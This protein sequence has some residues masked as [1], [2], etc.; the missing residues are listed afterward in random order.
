MD[1]HVLA[2]GDLGA[3]VKVFAELRREKIDNVE[4]ERKI[5]EVAEALSLSSCLARI[6]PPGAVH[7]S[8]AQ[9][10]SFISTA[11]CKCPP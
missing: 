5:Q 9:E 11:L 2:E 4:G 7:S 3:V 6:P 10:M 8:P 1:G